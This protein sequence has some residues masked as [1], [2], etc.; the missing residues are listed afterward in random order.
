MEVLGHFGTENYTR[1]F[2][3]V[4]KS[5]IPKFVDSDCKQYIAW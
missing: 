3:I 5:L 2:D 1:R 4:K